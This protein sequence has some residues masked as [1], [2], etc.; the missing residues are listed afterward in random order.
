MASI[1]DKPSFGVKQTAELLGVSPSTVY[2]ALYRKE[3]PGVKIGSKW[4]VPRPAL[5]A[6]MGLS[7]DGTEK[8]AK[9]GDLPE[10][11]EEW[12]FLVTVR[13]VRRTDEISNHS[14]R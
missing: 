1:P 11:D 4:I 13:R 5:P 7:D 12:T 3:I 9:P 8:P 10:Q 14:V 6:F 2:E